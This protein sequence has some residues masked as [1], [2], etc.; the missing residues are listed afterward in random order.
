M[1]QLA[2][3]HF[4]IE[5]VLL[6]IIFSIISST[7]A[8]Q[9]SR[10]VKFTSD[11]HKEMILIRNAL[12]LGLTFWL[13]HFF[14]S[15][16]IGLPHEVTSYITYS[17]INYT[18]CVIGSY[19][20]LKAAQSVVKKNTVRY[21]VMSGVIALSVILANSAG[22]IALFREYID[23]KPVL[24]IMSLFMIYGMSLSI[25]RFLLQI[26]H[27]SYDRALR[28]W[29]V[30]GSILTGAALAGAPYIM[31][32]S[33][34]DFSTLGSISSPLA[35]V[36]FLY[37]IIANLVLKVVPDLYSDQLY[38][39][40]TEV[41]TSLF[42][43]NPA[44]VFS[45]DITGRIIDV[46][47]EARK[48]S[49]YSYEELRGMNIEELFESKR[50]H[51]VVR[52]FKKVLSGSMPRL[53]SRMMR[54][55]RSFSE[56]SITA[57]R[58][59]TNG[60]VIGAFGIV[61]DITD[62]KRT[63]SR[64]EFLAYHDELTR[65]PNRRKLNK[66][67]EQLI[68]SDATFSY[69]LMDFDRFKRIN[70][71]YGHSF[72]DQLLKVTGRQIRQIARKYNATAVRLGGDEFL[73]V[74]ESELAEKAA[75]DVLSDFNKP[76]SVEGTEVMMT[77]S[78]GSAR[79]GEHTSD[80]EELLQYA[81]LAMYKAKEAGGNQLVEFNQSYSEDAGMLLG[82]ETELRNAIGEKELMV[83]YQPKVD[84]RT[85]R[86]EGAEALAR[87]DNKERG[88]VP[89]GIFIPLAEE[90]G[91]IVPL[92]QH[93]I[94]TVC[95]QVGEWNRNGTFTGRVSINI[96]LN[97]LLQE[98]FLGYVTSLMKTFEVPAELLEFEI[99]ER[100]VM[101]QEEY[102]NRVLQKLRTIGVTVSIDDFG[103]GYSS[104]SYLHKLHVDS[105]KMDRSF[106]LQLET[107][108]GV[109]AA[110]MSM[111]EN[112]GLNIIAEGVETIEQV[113]HLQKLGCHS[114]QGYYYSRPLNPVD[115][116]GYM[117]TKEVI[118]A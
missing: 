103:T 3:Y 75:R 79:F 101:K 95:E 56:V 73:I 74:C 60:Q 92:E 28:K 68:E 18:M 33:L 54:K 6:T 117:A 26:T 86:I 48:L 105:L 25:Y 43:H 84:S 71:T 42:N 72:G 16:S 77:A 53:Q 83:Y 80:A 90:S 35:L 104:L 2:F 51:N 118:E 12:L 81:D 5:Y 96:S 7:L 40:S 45:T 59:I 70:D 46:N 109:A 110:I 115:F 102:V 58:T 49:G 114:I 64:V 21:F 38:L 13:T 29:K 82:M 14:V 10:R 106:T 9:F 98:E 34:L 30:A 19:G 91:L 78:I 112:L 15:I 94:Y 89:P 65:L 116:E 107:D 50:K 32:T 87:W 57:I 41:Y 67:S 99:T 11:K 31:L 63:E 76:L 20:A 39:R 88:M 113:R 62:K 8:I 23:V 85:G 66:V 93:I 27:E 1:D 4:K 52:Y 37:V 44:A 17:V 22:F 61:E 108:P 36:P 100:L 24:L 55:D 69:I 111:A 97:T 47:N